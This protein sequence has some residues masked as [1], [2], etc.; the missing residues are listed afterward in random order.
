MQCKHKY[1]RG[2]YLSLSHAGSGK[3]KTQDFYILTS[4]HSNRVPIRKVLILPSLSFP[5]ACGCVL[6]VRGTQFPRTQLPQS[7]SGKFTR[8]RRP[9]ERRALSN[10]A[11]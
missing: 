11:M 7:G 4:D 10:L 3:P 6:G 5:V 2:F 1:P 8:E 9:G